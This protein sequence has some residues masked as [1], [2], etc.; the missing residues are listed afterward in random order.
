MKTLDFELRKSDKKSATEKEASS[1]KISYEERKQLDK[2]IRKLT[3]KIA[4]LEERL[5]L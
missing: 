3:N 4:K 2:D 1:N 5:R